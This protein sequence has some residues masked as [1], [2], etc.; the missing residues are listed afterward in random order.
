M[1]RS[2]KLG[3]DFKERC[4]RLLN[5][6]GSGAKYGVHKSSLVNLARG[7]AERVLATRDSEGVL[8]KP[9]RPESGVFALLSPIRAS[10]LRNMPSTTVVA[11]EDFP[12]LY[13]GRKR[14]IYEAAV[15]SLSLEAIKVSDAW[16][17]TFVKAEKINFSVKSD[18]PPRVIQ[19]RTPRYNVEVGKYLKCFEKNLF[20]SFRKCFGYQVI[21]KG[22]NA[23]DS[24]AIL[25]AN[26][27][28]FRNPVAV[29]LDA[30]RFDQHVSREALEFEHSVY[31][32]V[33][34]SPELARLLRM[35]L[36]NVGIGYTADGKVK[37]VVDGC[38]MSGDINTSMGNCL[39][40]SCIVLC[41]LKTTGVDMRLSNNGDDCVVFCEREHLPLLDGI[42]AWFE[43]FGFKLTLEPAVDIFEKIEFCQTQPVVVGSGW[44]M[45]RNPFTASAK[46]C[47]SLLPWDTKE[48]F[49]AWR[50]AI[51]TCGLEL[52]RG[53]PFWEAY[54]RR[55]KVDVIKRDCIEQVYDSGL[56]YMAKGCMAQTITQDSRYSF[57]LAFG[58]LPD[59]QESLEE[60]DVDISYD[61]YRPLITDEF[62]I[63]P[64]NYLLH[65]DAKERT[66]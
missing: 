1:V 57:Y 53:V 28:E 59:V 41:Y 25:R 45:V 18:P 51:G 19:P 42:G 39:I 4:V 46:D 17:S 34:D 64:L 49:D 8:R 16:V 54:Y 15:A 38:R 24:A 35:Q 32:S 23:D 50:C 29:G 48:D 55:L 47:V 36:R 6:Y 40:M 11:R 33:F 62:V 60:L 12:T 13:H 27:D 31:N 9:L 7:V 2:R 52:T 20:A 44:R 58:M 65:H 43:R 22:C 26:W 56:G 30:S 5:G 3:N 61:L 10:L 63:Q 14:A 66:A 21:V 37:Y